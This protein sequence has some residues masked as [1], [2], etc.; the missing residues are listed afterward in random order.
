M[1]KLDRFRFGNLHKRRIGFLV[2]IAAL[3]VVTAMILLMFLGFFGSRSELVRL[4][5]SS[6]VTSGK[7]EGAGINVLE[8]PDANLIDD[9]FFEK[10]EVCVTA[11]VSQAQDNYIYFKPAEGE[12]FKDLSVGSSVNVMSI[13]SEGNY[14]LRYSGNFK[15]FDVAR[16]AV[17]EIIDDSD[18]LWINDPIIKVLEQSGSMIYLTQSGKLISDA[19]NTL[20]RLV[21]EVDFCDICKFDSTVY[22]VTDSGDIYS[23]ADA[24]S[25]SLLYSLGLSDEELSV[26]QICAVNG[27]L[28]VMLSDGSVNGISGGRLLKTCDTRACEILSCESFLL[29]MDSDGN[30]YSSSNGIFFSDLIESN[31]YLTDGDL[32]TDI[33]SSGDE[34]YILTSY[35]RLIIASVQDGELSCENTDISSSE[36]VTICPTGDGNVLVV[37][38]D[39][40]AFLVTVESGIISSLGS[41]SVAV[42]DIFMKEEDRYIIRSGNNLFE[43]S[44]MSAIELDEPV[45]EDTVISGDL[46]TVSTYKTD[47]A[48]WILTGNTELESLDNGVSLT[49]AGDGI[50]SMTLVLDGTADELFEESLF[51][52]IEVKMSSPL[53]VSDAKVWLEG[54]TFGQEG[55]VAE[56]MN[57]N[58]DT[59]SSVFAVTEAMLNDEDIRFNISFEG[60][61]IINIESVYIGLDKYDINS[62]TEEFTEYITGEMPAALRFSSLVIG[63]TDFCP[64]DFYGNSADS[65]ETCM[66]LCK[67]SEASPWLVL[68]SNATS[69]DINNLMG[70]LCGS[71]ASEY[72]KKRI[73]NGTALQWSRQFETV[74]IEITDSDDVFLSDVQK[75]AYVSYIEDLFSKSEFY[76][77]LKD[78]IVFVDGMNYEGGVMLSGADRHATTVELASTEDT[79][80]L[81]SVMK[82]T[83]E[84]AMYNSP[85][86]ASSGAVGG[87][88]I[89]SVSFGDFKNEDSICAADIIS[90]VIQ[91]ESTFADLVMFDSDIDTMGALSSLRELID[92]GRLYLEVLDPVDSSSPYSSQVFSDSCDSMLVD[93]QDYVCLIVSNHSSTQQQFMA[94]SDSFDISSGF[95]RRY[96]TDG[97]LLIERS[98]N[99]LGLRQTLQSGQ[100]VMVFIPK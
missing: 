46:C 94:Q 14:G 60:T 77:E 99:R 58:A 53:G 63:S 19:S 69:S 24:S 23:S 5:M 50:H 20:T 7:T 54:D 25:F 88:L 90:F 22:A 26:E 42:D 67:S 81:A 92:G 61:G 79:D 68:G 80:D 96:S 78:E 11:T 41:A 29:V 91:S 39:N 38:S 49:G 17:L 74:Y 57:A 75:G 93:G 56:L 10:R 51:Y 97:K 1:N 2:F 98:S 32:V 40:Q 62:V 45:G 55:F 33:K 65:L 15:G 83:L 16:F 37:S 64:E 85:R 36:P 4:N 87:E 86:A 6:S 100:F 35:G 47:I 95:Y 12:Q 73:D 9:P 8:I 3:I 84:T 76:V 30:L 71:V 21:S 28:V 34:F 52:R 27:N 82:S 66:K 18:G 48:S 89:S 44:V 72:G 31:D 43:T 59:Y 13:D 70:Y